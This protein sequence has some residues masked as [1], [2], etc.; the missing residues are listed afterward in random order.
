LSLIGAL[1]RKKQQ[2]FFIVALVMKMVFATATI[3]HSCMVSQFD[4]SKIDLDYQMIQILNDYDEKVKFFC[5]IGIGI[6]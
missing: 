4:W 6:D 1:Q 5:F 2:M 3:I